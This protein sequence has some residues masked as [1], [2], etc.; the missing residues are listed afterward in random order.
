M[1]GPLTVQIA[2]PKLTNVT[3]SLVADVIIRLDRLNLIKQINLIAFLKLHKPEETALSLKQHFP[4]QHLKD[5]KGASQSTPQIHLEL[6]QREGWGWCGGYFGVGVGRG[7]GEGGGGG[8][9]A[10][11]EGG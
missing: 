9:E 1:A 7:W 11:A 5:P 6:D 3:V 10:G 2:E 8:E 4:Q